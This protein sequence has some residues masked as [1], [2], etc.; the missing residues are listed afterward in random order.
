MTAAAN[1]ILDASWSERVTRLRLGIAAG[2]A[3]GRG[4]ALPGLGLFSENVPRPHPLPKDPRTVLS[5]DAG[6]PSLR[7]SPSGRFALAYPPEPPPP[8]A[9]V[10][11]RLVDP[12][13]RY[14]PRR[15]SVPTPSLA[16]V[17][18]ADLANAADP[19]LPLTPRSF[20]PLL[21]PGA[22]YAIAAG[23]TVLRGLVRDGTTSLPVPWARVEARTSLDVID[24]QGNTVTIHPV[25]GRAQGD[26]RGE[27]V[28]VVGTLPRDIVVTTFTP[29][30]DLEIVVRARPQPVPF[31]AS[32]TP[33]ESG[34]DPLWQLPVEQ[35]IDLDPLGGVAVGT[36]LPPGYT[37]TATRM[38]TCRRGAAVH[39]TAPFTPL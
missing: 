20:L 28:L 15:F 36:T 4:S 18:A 5:P 8:G 24:D 22:A 2:D 11:V 19:T 14:V 10:E 12:H 1:Q 32:A 9:R 27:F 30:I 39:L 3:L 31:A 38:I 17:L 35:A 16:T 21:Y 34:R 7:R 13:R 25:L 29:T 26:D 33:L 37:T 23:S 6:L